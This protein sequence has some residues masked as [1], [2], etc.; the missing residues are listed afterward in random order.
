MKSLK[1]L[2]SLCCFI[3][4]FIVGGGSVDAQTGDQAVL[5]KPVPKEGD[6]VR[7]GLDDTFAPMGFRND[8]GEVVGF[9]I[10]LAKA[11]GD[12]YGWKMEFQPIDWA[13]KE[14]ELNTGNIDMI[15][16]GLGITPDREKQMLFSKTYYESPG[17][18][19][20]KK[21]SPIQKLEDLE[22]KKV[23]TQSGSTT[24]KYIQAWP[25]G[26]YQ[27]LN[28][29][30]V[31][32]SSYNEVFSDLDSGRVDAVATDSCYGRYVMQV[33]GADK[34][35]FFVDDSHPAEPFGVG[36]RL[37]DQALKEKIDQ[38]ISQ[39]KENGKYDQIVEKWFG[40][41]REVAKQENLLQKIL[42]SLGKGFELTVGLFVIVLVM[43]LPLGFLIAIARVFGASWI[44]GL[45]EGYVFIMRGSPLMLQLMVFF[46]GLPYIGIT[47]DRMPAAIL[48]FV[49]NYAAY[50][51]EIFRGGIM[52]VPG[53]QYESI[54]VLGIGKYRG[55][56][57]II[58]PQ[59]MNITL[60]S[61]GNE[62]IALVKDTSLV[63]VIGLGEL[64]R[65]GSISA[66]TYATIV[67]YLVCG[68]FYLV[69]T[70]VVT[71]GLKRLENQIHWG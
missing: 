60:P 63:Y 64:L 6:T 32:Y 69:F 37:G 66:N 41:N 5:E 56:R 12:L 27:K 29:Q 2:V 20:T 3:S 23:S 4:F 53:G 31:L 40:Q 14:T 50:F 65:A 22:G 45:I 1:W 36:M 38:G 55:F 9:D 43:S 17:I 51:A 59:V 18:I 8:K 68:V 11:I 34:Y 25:N 26:L 71:V 61:V 24:A 21:G 42:P 7:V 35:A 19:I 70:A 13:M 33:R 10:D 52:A 67:P 44:R 48:A 39:L 47:L 28:G 15:W 46:F 58:F 54:K 62:V 16:N 49:I 57:R 30:P